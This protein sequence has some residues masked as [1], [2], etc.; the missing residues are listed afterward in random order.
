MNFSTYIAKRYLISKKSNN[1]IN[2]ISWISIIAIAIT[3]AALV[4]ILSAMNGLTSIVANLYNTL[5]PDLK[6][7]IKNEKTF[8]VTNEKLN[9]IKTINGVQSTCFCLTD[10]ALLKNDDK[11]TLVTV[12]GIDNNFSKVTK[13]KTAITEGHSDLENKNNGNTVIIGKGI[14]NQLGINL[15]GYVNELILYSPVKGKSSGLTMD[16]QLNQ[17]YVSPQG[18]F[19]INDEFDYQ[20]V[21]VDIKTARYLFDDS[22][23]VS[24]IEVKCDEN[25]IDEV[26]NQIQ[27]ILGNNYEVKNRYQLN[28]VLFK[29][30]ETEKLA[31]FIILAFILIIATFNIIGALTMLIIEKK[32]D[33]KTLYSLGASLKQIREIFMREGLLITGVGALIGLALGLIVCLLQVKFHLVKFGD[34]F[35][36]PYY[37]IELRLNDF[38]W[39]FSLIMVIGFVAAF[40]PVRLFT[41]ND[42]VKDIN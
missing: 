15:N 41:K 17:I 30:L 6:I 22:V 1:A 21:F 19:S 8:N 3:T 18:I 35:V 40:Y 7:T 34:E 23:K 24:S 27:N 11:Q 20:F 16:E 9:A 29:T 12:K 38:F 32:K 13:F 25:K 26:Q 37:P 4:I 14:A 36:V 28:D 10:K 33:I 31:T 39:I 5:E 42:L 2:V